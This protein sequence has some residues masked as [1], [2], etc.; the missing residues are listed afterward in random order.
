MMFL[1]TDGGARGNPGPGAL[2]AVIFDS[3]GKTVFET[4]VYLGT[5]TNNEAEYQALLTGLQAALEKNFL[6]ITCRLDSEL[7]VKQLKGEYKVKN[8]RLTIFY[9]KVKEL[10]KKFKS[11]SYK[12]IPRTQNKEADALVNQVL[13]TLNQ[14]L[15]TSS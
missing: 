7:V 1:N 9:K 14:V 12:H 2:G 8:E 5:C 15:D 4:G 6:E 3:L 11:I 10:E 13:D